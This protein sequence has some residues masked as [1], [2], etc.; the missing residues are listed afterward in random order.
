MFGA[1]MFYF[2]SPILILQIRNT[3]AGKEKK[4]NYLYII[5]EQRTFKYILD[6]NAL[7]ILGGGTKLYLNN[8]AASLVSRKIELYSCDGGN[9]VELPDLP[10]E[11]FGAGLAWDSDSSVLYVCGGASWTKAYS[12]CYSMDLR[13]HLALFGQIS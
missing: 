6:E 8:Q 7:L 11:M 1:E 4:L 5:K 10:Q 3:F 12:Q 2:I 13:L 9:S